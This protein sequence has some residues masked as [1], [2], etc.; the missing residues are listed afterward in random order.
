MEEIVKYKKERV[1][2]KQNVNNIEDVM[3]GALYAERFTPDGFFK[4]STPG[5]DQLHLSLQENT[6]G[7]SLF[8]S[9][10]QSVWPVY[11]TINELPPNLR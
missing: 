7:V 2:R 1:Q 4:D 11:F 8:K 3:D 5:D 9:T 6:D 10:K